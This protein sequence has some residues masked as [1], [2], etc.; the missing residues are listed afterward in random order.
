MLSARKV[1]VTLYDPSPAWRCDRMLCQEIPK[2]GLQISRAGGL[3]I[4]EDSR[5]AL[6]LVIR[7]LLFATAVPVATQH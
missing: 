1:H 7:G 2:V 6:V 4:F 5:S 3:G